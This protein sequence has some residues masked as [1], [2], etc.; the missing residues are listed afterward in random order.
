MFLIL[1]S[2]LMGL[3]SPLNPLQILWLNL[4]TDGAPAVALAMEGPEPGIMASGPR[5]PKEPLIEKVG[6]FFLILII[7]MFV[8]FGVWFGFLFFFFC[9]VAFLGRLPLGSPPH[10]SP[11]RL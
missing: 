3:Q 2:T 10:H 6:V 5:S 11:P 1:A 4:A 9:S 8:L 7:F